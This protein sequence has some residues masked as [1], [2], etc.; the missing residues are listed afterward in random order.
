MLAFVP[1]LWRY[2]VVAEVFSLNAFIAVVLL[3]L[4]LVWH[5]APH[6]RRLLWAAGF[7][8]G[9]GVANQ[10]AIVLIAP[11]CGYLVVDG[12]R[13]V[14]QPLGWKLGGLL[15]AAGCGL[16]GLLG[17]LCV[18]LA[19]ATAPLLNT[20]NASSL[21]AFWTLITRADIGT[22]RLGPVGTGSPLQQIA[23]FATYVWTAFTQEQRIAP[24]VRNA[25]RRR[26]D[27]EFRRVEAVHPRRSRL[28]I[29]RQAASE[30]RQRRGSIPS[31][32][33]LRRGQRA[34]DNP[35]RDRVQHPAVSHSRSA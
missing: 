21:S 34:L 15:G 9:L 35:H 18:P 6:R 5:D 19:A 1:G 29:Q 2:S 12:L 25:P 23:S 4:V 17:Y 24:R 14:Q 10:Q 27:A 3:G 13:K 11:A 20:D 8:F 30:Q 31:P 7:V 22:F 28:Q 26:R 16:L 33:D 32:A